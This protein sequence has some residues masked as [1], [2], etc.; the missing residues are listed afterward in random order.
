MLRDASRHQHDARHHEG[1]SSM[2]AFIDTKTIIEFRCFLSFVSNLDPKKG[3][4]DGYTKTQKK[5][6]E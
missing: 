3:V 2:I 6:E 4:G 5:K 1:Q